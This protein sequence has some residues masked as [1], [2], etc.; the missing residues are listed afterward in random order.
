MWI[1]EYVRTYNL[2]IFNVEG[3]GTCAS[4][5]LTASNSLRGA[6]STSTGWYVMRRRRRRRRDDTTRRH[7]ETSRQAA[8]AGASEPRRACD[9]RPV[10][11]RVLHTCGRSGTVAETTRQPKGETLQPQARR[12]DCTLSSNVR[13][14]K[15]C[16]VA[17]R[18]LVIGIGVQ[19][20][21]G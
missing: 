12:E 14:G 1:P 4:R 20:T 19:Y 13:L 16:D 8:T 11:V 2:F 5:C 6:G 18:P 10:L 9:L 3:G 15:G 21:V 17:S 7:D